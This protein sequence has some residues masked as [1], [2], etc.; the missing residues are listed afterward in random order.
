MEVDDEDKCES[1]DRLRIGNRV[2]YLSIAPVTFDR[3]TLF[4]PLALL[5][6]LPYYD[7]DWTVVYISRDADSG[8]LKTSLFNRKFAGV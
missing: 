4:F 5:P 6:P 2:K 7:D 1:E 3:D 8:E